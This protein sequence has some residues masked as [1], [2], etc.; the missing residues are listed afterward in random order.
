MNRLCSTTPPGRAGLIAEQAEGFVY[1]VSREGVT[2]EQ[3]GLAATVEG[4]IAMLRGKTSLPIA[5]GFG[6]STPEHA[7]A[8]AQAADAIVVGSA[9]VRRIG[10]YGDAPDLAERVAEFVRPLVEA[11]KSVAAI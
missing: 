3:Q 7:R 2:G 4:Q 9:I 10:T 5:I 11:T 1:Y 6:I 8:A